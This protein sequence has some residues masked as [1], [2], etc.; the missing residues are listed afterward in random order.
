MQSTNPYSAG[1]M[2]KDSSMFFGRDQELRRIGKSSL[3]YQ[4]AYQADALPENVITVYLDLQDA[5][6][7]QPLD[8]LAT[9]RAF[10]R[11]AQNNY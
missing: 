2:V 9:R 7:R 4:L 11:F 8:Q 1:G 10:A 5:D 6:H 3:L